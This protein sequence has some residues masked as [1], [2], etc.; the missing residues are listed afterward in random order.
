M[1]G[2]WGLEEVVEGSW[3]LEGRVGEV[4]GVL[5][6]GETGLGVE[7]GG[8][9]WFGGGVIHPAIHLPLLSDSSFADWVTRRLS[10]ATEG[11]Y[12]C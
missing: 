10:S 2:G 7:G 4:L 3:G 8:W 1:V 12:A 11:Q 9:G 6:A 5:D